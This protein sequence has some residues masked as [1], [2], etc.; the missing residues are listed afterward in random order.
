MTRDSEATT[1]SQPADAGAVR[2]A[3]IMA[4]DPAL[5]LACLAAWKSDPALINRYAPAFRP[6]PARGPRAVHETDQET[7]RAVRQSVLDELGRGAQAAGS[8][9][10]DDPAFRRMAEFAV[11]E[12]VGDEFVPLLREQAGFEKDRRHI[13]PTRRPAEDFEVIVIGAGMVGINAGVKLAEAGFRYTIF[14]ERENL[15]GTWWINTYPGAAVDTPSHYYSFSF[16]LN[17]DWQRYYPAGPEYLA[18]LRRVA[19]KY[20]VTERIRFSTRVIAC[21]WDAGTGKWNVT[22]ERDGQRATH[23]ATAL[24]TATGFL[25]RPAK[26][27]LPG[28]ESF[29]GVIVH[30]AEWDHAVELAGKRVVM[31]GT[32]CTAVQIATDIAD[33]VGTL[34]VVQR[35]PHWIA[36]AKTLEGVPAETRWL[37]A[38]VPYYHQ[39]FRLRT[40]WFASD[41]NYD[42]PRIDWEWFAT[43][44][45]ASPANDKV[46]QVCLKYLD[47]MFGDRPDLKAKLTPDFPPYAK[48]IIKDPGYYAVLRRPDVALHTGVIDRLEPGTVILSDGTR[49]PCDVLILATG[50]TLD[51]LSTIDIRGRGGV[52]LG[53]AW[54]DPRAY[55]GVCTPGFPNLFTTAGPNTAPNHGGGHNLTGEEQV[56]F[57]TEC[58]QLMVERDLAAIEVTSEATS[59]YNKLVDQ[60]LDKTVWQHGKSAHGY[61]RNAVGRA[62]VACPWRMVDYWTRLRAPATGDFI[63]TPAG[64]GR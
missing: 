2:A 14:E 32:G 50:F 8:A 59:A 46:M 5:L 41:N 15:G 16:E 63:L 17:P 30:S 4:A 44:V 43:H 36:P 25:N 10:L 13:K 61:Y 6:L 40:Y 33:L 19:D 1:A 9:V 27:D 21:A 48:R 34:T 37:L 11:G 22:T 7:A 42:T 38:N 3:A 26:P 55:L 18:Y 47:E 45:S 31:L 51:F 28:R 56:H 23:V 58:L 57:I 12:P 35:Q 62:V 53:D 52:R 54:R 39:W 24:I 20:Q 29:G 49:V 60:E 64:A